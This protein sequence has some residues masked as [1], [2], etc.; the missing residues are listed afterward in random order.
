MT[1]QL[2]TGN[3]GLGFVTKEKRQNKSERYKPR[4]LGDSLK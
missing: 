3:L 2:S 1:L 4:I